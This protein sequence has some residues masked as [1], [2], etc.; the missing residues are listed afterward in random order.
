MVRYST[1]QFNTVWYGAVGYSRAQFS[2]VWY[3]RAQFNMVWYSTAQFS[4]VW[5]YMVQAFVVIWNDKTV[6][7]IRIHFQGKMLIFAGRI[8]EAAIIKI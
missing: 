5:Y 2:M 6:M 7:N 8:C 3:S 1:A 4:M